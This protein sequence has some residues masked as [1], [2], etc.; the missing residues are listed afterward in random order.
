V[1]MKP[2]APNTYAPK[3]WHIVGFTYDG[4]TYCTECVAYTDP[5]VTG[6]SPTD[7]RV[8][9]PAPIFIS[10]DHGYHKCAVCESGVW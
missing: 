3:A 7:T 4:A 6:E 8:D 10:D 2:L 5:T 1:N 9:M